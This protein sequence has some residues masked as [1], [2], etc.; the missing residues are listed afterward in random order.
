MDESVLRFFNGYIGVFPGLW[1]LLS[2]PWAGIA[3]AALALFLARRAEA[4][5]WV[6][7]ALVAVALS[8]I[9]VSRVLKPAFARDRPCAVA[10]GVRVPLE[11][12]Q[13]Q[14]G[15]GFAMPS[16]H[17]SNTMALAAALASPDLALVSVLVGVSRVVTGQH[18]PSDVAA[19]WGGGLGVGTL[20][21]F[22]FKKGLGWR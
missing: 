22:A 18:W 1:P 14:C 16:A 11:S 4:M 21:R 5:R 19:G 9:T 8:D 10:E 20:L 15:A 2:S 12:G 6:L 17:A 13:A 3:L 7:P